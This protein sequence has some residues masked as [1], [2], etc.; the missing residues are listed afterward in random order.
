ME[1]TVLENPLLENQKMY[2]K[3]QPYQNLINKSKQMWKNPLK[4][5]GIAFLVNFFYIYAWINKINAISIICYILLGY[6][7]FNL[8]IESF[9]LSID[10][11]PSNLGISL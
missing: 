10:S 2:E 8:F 5:F 7:T 9:F 6:I 3:I 4:G 11:T 1:Q